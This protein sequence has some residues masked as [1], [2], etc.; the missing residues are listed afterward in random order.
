MGACTAESNIDQKPNAG[1]VNVAADGKLQNRLNIAFGSFQSISDRLSQSYIELENQVQELRHELIKADQNLAQQQSAKDLLAEQL[2]LVVSLMPVAVLILD[3]K[4]VISQ[5]NSYAEEL[6]GTELAGKLWI[7][8]ISSFFSPKPDDGHE[9]SLKNGRLV[10]I[11]T[12]S[13]SSD[14]G[15]II[16]LND[17]TETRNLQ[18]RLNHNKKLSE[19][20]KMT[21]SLAHQIRTPLA[22][23]SLYAD[24][25][26]CDGLSEIGRL[27]YAT[28]IKRQL[29]HLE[30]CVQD[31]LVFSKAGIMLNCVLS[32][33]ELVQ[34]IQLQAEEICDQKNAS[35][36]FN[37]QFSEGCVR[38]NKEL[39]LSVMANL[40]ENGIEACVNARVHPQLH[41]TVTKTDQGFLQVQIK[42]DG[43]GID[44]EY[45]EKIMEPFFTT[46]SSG[47]GLGLA[48]ANAV[49]DAHGGCFSIEN[50][51]TGG[52]VAQIKLPLLDQKNTKGAKK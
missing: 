27:N 18:A 20:G 29:T 37:N 38:C 40:I 2:N 41:M 52:A 9:I 30:K 3:G 15:Q 16:V 1:V 47:T 46:K 49:I 23:A 28:K 35:I 14:A 39:L 36:S 25:L 32:V 34:V 6:I 7:S 26:A 31:M 11:A 12:Q 33:P 43:E 48:V 10:S 51:L 13:L 44:S 19:M 17:Q 24:R 21:A 5:A 50:S 4:G 42:D 8:I 45:I 22:T